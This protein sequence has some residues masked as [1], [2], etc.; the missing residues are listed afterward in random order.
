MSH[1]IGTFK[2][3]R[4]RITAFNGH[5]E[6]KIEMKS[7]GG[8][9]NNITKSPFRP[10]V[11]YYIVCLGKK[12]IFYFSAAGPGDEFE[13]WVK[14]TEIFLKFPHFYVANKKNQS[15]KFKMTRHIQ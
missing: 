1:H 7:L 4:S 11:L 6:K 15:G 5:F 14:R 2:M 13:N 10:A 8:L 12:C 9:Y 3:S